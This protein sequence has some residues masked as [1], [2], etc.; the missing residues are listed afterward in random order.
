[1]AA[2]VA[3]Y[4][5]AEQR[6]DKIKKTEAGTELALRLERTDDVLSGLAARR[7]PG[8]VIVGFAT[9]TGDRA[10]EYGRRCLE[11][12]TAT[13]DLGLRITGLFYLA[14]AHNARGEHAQA[15]DRGVS[16]FLEQTT[17]AA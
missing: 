2:A 7:R 4:R 15:L 13:S 17:A 10:L 11:R 14:H 5:P 1:M 6:A 12:A 16:G 9:E 3:D 8:Q